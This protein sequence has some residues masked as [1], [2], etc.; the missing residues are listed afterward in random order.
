MSVVS[1]V[2]PSR[3][4]GVVTGAGRG[5][6]RAI[7]VALA[8]R[9]LDVALVSRTRVELEETAARVEGLG[10]R[11]LAVPCDVALS[12][13]VE[14][15][16]DVIL[17]D[18]GPPRVL[19]NNAGVVKRARVEDTTEADWDHVLD[20]NLKGTFLVTRAFLPSMLAAKSGRCIFV[21]SI[22]ATLGAPEQSAYCAS[23]WGVV[24]FMKSLAEELRGTGLQAACVLPGS[25]DTQMLDRTRFHP[26][27]TPEDVAGV[28]AYAA[29]DAPAAIHGSAIEVFGA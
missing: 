27:M 4:C 17:R 6:G 12:G 5:I 13:E 1:V 2:R 19:V 25:V 16:R 15:A 14:R 21:A 20:V 24:G 18:L 29:L 28:V 10:Q 3:G 9:G 22:S 11:A 8:S 26:Q 23:K 7:A